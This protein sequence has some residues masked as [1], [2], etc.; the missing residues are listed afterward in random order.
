LGRPKPTFDCLDCSFGRI[1]FSQI[2]S[3]PQPVR[4]TTKAYDAEIGSAVGI[5]FPSPS[6]RR[7]SAM[8]VFALGPP[9]HRFGRRPDEI[10]RVS[11]VH[12][13]TSTSKSPWLD[14][15]R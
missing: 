12:E 10:D 9:L 4:G 8:I 5:A 7:Q 11:L 1:G 15:N 3:A 13:R 14:P 2:S 6:S